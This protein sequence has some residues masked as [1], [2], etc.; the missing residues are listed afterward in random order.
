MLDRRTETCANGAVLTF[1]V[2]ASKGDETMVAVRL[3]GAGAIAKARSL[4]EKGWQVII[5]GPDGLS[6]QPPEFDKLLTMHSSTR[7]RT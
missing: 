5:T 2:N 6:Y 3:S 4:I 1:I 7:S